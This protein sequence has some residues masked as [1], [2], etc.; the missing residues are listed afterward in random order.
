M[1]PAGPTRLV[2][3]CRRSVGIIIAK[4]SWPRQFTALTTAP[5]GSRR[6]RQRDFHEGQEENAAEL[7]SLLSRSGFGHLAMLLGQHAGRGNGGKG[8]G[9]LV[10][11]PA[12]DVA[13][14]AHHGL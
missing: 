9:D 8:G 5:D 10:L 7:H 3:R 14:A 2:K 13:V 6:N 11:P 1:M 4:P 12:H